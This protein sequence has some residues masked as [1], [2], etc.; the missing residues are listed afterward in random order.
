MYESHQPQQEKEAKTAPPLAVGQMY[1]F[2][3]SAQIPATGE[4]VRGQ[5]VVIG[6]DEPDA[7][8]RL[9]YHVDFSSY[10]RLEL[11]A[12]KAKPAVHCT[13]LTVRAPESEPDYVTVTEDGTVG[14]MTRTNQAANK[15]AFAIGVAATLNAVDEAHAH[16]KMGRV[17][18]DMGNGRESQAR[19][20]EGS[21]IHVERCGAKTLHAM[22]VFSDVY[23]RARF[24]SGGGIG[25]AR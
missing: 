23:P 13:Y 10:G 16:R 11:R 22:P 8:R 18:M 15:H 6:R 19:L 5:Y 9:R 7:L 24:V 25:S 4:R 12:E 21:V 3:L 20:F 2:T 14:H 1:V 17:L